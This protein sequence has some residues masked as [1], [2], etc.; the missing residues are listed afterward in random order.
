MVTK[1]T[2]YGDKSIAE[3]AELQHY[4][5]AHRAAIVDHDAPDASVGYQQ[6]SATAEHKRCD[7][8]RPGQGLVVGK[9]DGG[10]VRNEELPVPAAG[11]T[12]ATLGSDAHSPDQLAVDFETATQVVHELLPVT[13]EEDNEY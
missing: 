2:P 10:Q 7:L 8:Q 5:T 6:V 12:V 1:N 13:L 9:S 4:R 11:V 3:I